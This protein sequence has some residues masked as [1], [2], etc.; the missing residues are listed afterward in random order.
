MTELNKHKRFL[1]DL[2][3]KESV[4]AEIGVWEGDFSVELNEVVNPTKFYLVDPWKF[5]DEY[6]DRWYGGFTGGGLVGDGYHNQEDM[7]KL[8]QK[9]KDK[10]KGKSNVEFLR[11]FSDDLS[12]HIL[13]NSLDWVYIDGDHSY[14][15]VLKDLVLSYSLVKKGGYI[16]GDDWS[17]DNDIAKAITTFSSSI[18]EGN[19]TGQVYPESRQFIIKLENK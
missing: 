11:I 4:G 7:D 17:Q 12:K 18:P 3:P 10:F 19:L 5:M 6:P 13:P 8:Y 2:L 9:V 1:L 16:T 14:E 15:Q